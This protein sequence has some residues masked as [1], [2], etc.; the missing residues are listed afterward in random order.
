MLSKASTDQ[1]G[2]D[3]M[4]FFLQ[5]VTVEYFTFVYDSSHRGNCT[6]IPET[7]QDH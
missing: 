4:I 6:H 7:S 2:G 5:E 1:R 3:Q